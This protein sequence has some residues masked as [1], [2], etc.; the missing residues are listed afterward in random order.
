MRVWCNCIPTNPI[1]LPRLSLLNQHNIYSYIYL[2]NLLN[3]SRL[4]PI[5]NLLRNS[6]PLHSGYR[7]WAHNMLVFRVNQRIKLPPMHASN[8]TLTGR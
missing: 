4:Q 6:Y 8:I 7:S 3:Y 1:L 2:C 5:T